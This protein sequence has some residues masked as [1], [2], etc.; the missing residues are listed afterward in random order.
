MSNKRTNKGLLALAALAAML[1]ALGLAACGGSD[2][3]SSSSGGST[4]AETAEATEAGGGGEA[5][6]E[7]SVAMVEILTGVQFGVEIKEGMEDFAAE[8]G[9]VDLSVQ[10]PPSTEPEV[11]QKMA[12]DLLAKSPDAMGVAPFPPELWT[13]TMKTITEQVDNYLVF[14]ERPSSEPQDVSAAPI[15]LFVG[16]DDKSEAREMLEAAIEAAKLPKSETGTVILG[17]CVAQEAG[18]LA[19]RTEGFEEALAKLL[20]N[21]KVDKFTSEVE[22]QANTEAW[23][24]KLAAE[25]NPVLATG[26][27][28]QDGTS[29]YKVKK[30]K[31][32]DF[33]VGAMELP[34]EVISGLKDGSILVAMG[35]NWWLQG[36]TATRMLAEAA[37]GEELPE[38]WVNTGQQLFTGEDVAAVEERASEPSKF[39]AAGIEELFGNGMPEAE[40]IE[41]AWK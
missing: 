19:Q 9:S 10:G 36:Y 32:Y 40:P 21:A 35:T 26:T 28:D 25:P 31:G 7:V 3:D 34:P 17:Q 15:Q 1:L 37:R 29:L 41:N 22:P 13:R 16:T 18:V 2:D 20:P 11:A 8:D 23:T 6:E 12:T 38:G 4:E 5:K 24:T 33:A 30:A 14:N 27:C 39:Y